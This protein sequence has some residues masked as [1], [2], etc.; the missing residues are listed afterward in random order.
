MRMQEHVNEVSVAFSYGVLSYL[1]MDF[2]TAFESSASGMILNITEEPDN[3]IEQLIQN[4]QLGLGVIGM[5]MNLSSYEIEPLFSCRHVAVVNDKSVLAEKA[6]LDYWDLDHQAIALV[7][8]QF[9]PYHQNIYRF[10]RAGITPESLY[11]TSEI[12]FTHSYAAQNKGIGISVDF[13]AQDNPYP[14]TRVL[15]FKDAG[16]TWDVCLVLRK[17][18]HPTK[19]EQFFITFIKKYLECN[20]RNGT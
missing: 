10:K 3:E 15:H 17:G 19:A 14:N 12:N 16:F 18:Y 9:N 7:G 8:H 13:V 1:G 20:K 4:G 2:K 11:E 5:P 6:I